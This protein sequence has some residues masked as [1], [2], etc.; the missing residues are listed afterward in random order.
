[1]KKGLFLDILVE[2]KRD[3]IPFTTRRLMQTVAN[4]SS[5]VKFCSTLSITIN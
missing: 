1:M 4:S 5:S 2:T 3:D